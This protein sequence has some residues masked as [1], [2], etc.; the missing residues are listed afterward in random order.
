M[1]RTCWRV[2]RA[3]P[4]GGMK[5]GSGAS[6]IE[7]QRR[8]GGLLGGTYLLPEDGVTEIW[9]TWREK[10]HGRTCISSQYELFS[11]LKYEYFLMC[12]LRSLPL[13]GVSGHDGHSTAFP[14][15]L[16]KS[17]ITGTIRS[18]WLLN[19]AA[20]L[21][22]P[23]TLQRR[24]E[25]LSAVAEEEAEG[26]RTAAWPGLVWVL[27]AMQPSS[28]GR[29]AGSVDLCCGADA[30]LKINQL[31]SLIALASTCQQPRKLVRYFTKIAERPHD[32]INFPP[33]RKGLSV[34]GR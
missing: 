6:G 5:V 25:D 32:Y 16:F 9:I 27:E 19:S 21:L 20:E 33:F 7:G 1:A 3:L 34:D 29:C 10:I 13:H 2:G 22:L 30:S 11:N 4:L 28:A 12:V 15:D 31:V 24:R 8:E 18:L 23:A 14:F 17:Q 26:S